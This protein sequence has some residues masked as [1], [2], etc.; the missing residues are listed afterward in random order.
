[1]KHHFDVIC[2]VVEDELDPF[3][4]VINK[5]VNKHWSQDG[6]LGDTTCQWP[7]PGHR[8][9]DD[10]PLATATQP[11]LYPANSP[12]LKS[13]SLQ[14][15]DRNVGWVWVAKTYLIRDFKNKLHL[16]P[17]LKDTCRTASTQWFL[18]GKWCLEERAHTVIG[19]YSTNIIISA[20]H[21][22]QWHWLNET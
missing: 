17:P 21:V 11:T 15:R 8:T 2:K 1:M 19:P 4:Y 14:F 22:S 9:I 20:R 7:P 3:I 5:V 12:A 13:I 16:S 10:N 18:C 6:P